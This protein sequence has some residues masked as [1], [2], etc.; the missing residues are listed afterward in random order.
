[1]ASNLDLSF[2]TYIL[3]VG[4][5]DLTIFN[6]VPP[7]YITSV[8]RSSRFSIQCQLIRV[9]S[10]VLS[11]DGKNLIIPISSLEM[12]ADARKEERYFFGTDEKAVMEFLNPYDN[13]TV[14]TKN[15]IEM[16]ASGTSIRT[17]YDSKLFE[18]DFHIENMTIL[19]NGKVNKR[20]KGRIVYKKSFLNLKGKLHYQVGIQFI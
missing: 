5:K 10:K 9:T 3:N 7:K 16:S 11:S 12:V 20:V 6:S 19:L 17:P 2:Q 13:Q 4:E 15:I 8:T 14:I 1:S 18:K